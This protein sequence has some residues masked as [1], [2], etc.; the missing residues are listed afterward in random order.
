MSEPVQS[1]YYRRINFNIQ[2]LRNE[3]SFSLP[4]NVTHCM[5]SVP[6]DNQKYS[7]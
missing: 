4:T 6:G 7:N 5:E 1:N 2:S 3:R